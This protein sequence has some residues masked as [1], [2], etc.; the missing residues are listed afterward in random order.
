MT[1]Q[2]KYAIRTVLAALMIVALPFQ[3]MADDDF[4]RG[5]IPDNHYLS[6]GSKSV[7]IYGQ[8]G[9]NGG[10]NYFRIQ[11]NGSDALAVTSSG[12][13]GIGT[14]SPVSKLDV[15]G[16]VSIGTYAGTTAAAANGMVVSGTVG[17]GTTTTS[18][19]YLQVVNTSVLTST[20]L[21]VAS[22]GSI[23][24]IAEFTVGGSTLG[25][26]VSA[27]GGLVPRQFSLAQVDSLTPIAVGELIMVN[28]YG[29]VG[30]NGSSKYMMCVATGTSIDQWQVVGSSSNT[31][32][33]NNGCGVAR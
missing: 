4:S 28:N 11:T 6:W 25:V 7:M 16:N 26:R 30:T 13:T 5:N 29:P 18:S 27:L 2:L 9:A 22:S 12:G 15:N 17:I 32:G 10:S 33:L 24:D 21:V 14:N 20:A 23:V 19:A 31:G 8:S 3:I 1:K